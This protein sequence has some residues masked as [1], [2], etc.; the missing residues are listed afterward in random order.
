MRAS[1]PFLSVNCQTLSGLVAKPPSESAIPIGKVAI[2]LLVFRSTRDTVW[3]PQFGTQRLSK[4]IAKPEQ[5]ALPTVMVSATLL[6]FGSMRA[7]LFLGLFEIQTAS[8]TA[9]QSGV[10][11]T[12][13]TASGFNEVMG[14][15]MPGVLTPG[16]ADGFS[17]PWSIV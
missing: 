10:P 14:I 5:G 15:W 16:L 6:V 2:T 17:C 13:N 1:V 12:S 3:S 9:I 11:G 4:P 8:P 7:T